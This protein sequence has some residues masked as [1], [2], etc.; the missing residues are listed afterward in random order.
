[1]LNWFSYLSDFVDAGETLVI[2]DDVATPL[3]SPVALVEKEKFEEAPF[4]MNVS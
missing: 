3:D 2:V 4:N 1:M